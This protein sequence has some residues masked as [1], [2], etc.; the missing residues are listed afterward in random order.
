MFLYKFVVF[1]LYLPVK[2]FM[3]TKV[4]GNQVPKKGKFIIT[5]NH[6]SFND[7]LTVG[8]Y[9]KRIINF[10]AKKEIMQ[11][12]LVA[13]FM[14]R[15]GVITV[16]RDKP[17]I[18]SF[19]AVYKV[20]KDD[21]VLGIFPEGTRNRSEDGK[22]LPF[23]NGVALFAIK[24][25][26]PIIPMLLVRKPKFFRRNQLIIGEPFELSDFYDKALEKDV[27][28]EATS[29]LYNKTLELKQLATINSKKIK[30]NKKI[31]KKS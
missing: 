1:L 25:R 18:S 12:R 26:S 3:P 7:I 15:M 29:I 17:D 5:C 20:L 11:N 8:I 28:D 30:K 14:K 22:L 31:D 10:V 21:G 6:Q 2:I 19:K 27:L 9:I 13:W 24:T 23:K 16:D 4:I